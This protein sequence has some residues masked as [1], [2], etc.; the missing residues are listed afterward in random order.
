MGAWR[1]LFGR[2]MGWPR[3]I[4]L[5]RSSTR[6]NFIGAGP[7]QPGQMID[8]LK[9]NIRIRKWKPF[10]TFDDFRSK[11]IVQF[12]PISA[13][14]SS[15]PWTKPLGSYPFRMEAMSSRSITCRTRSV[16]TGCNTKRSLPVDFQVFDHR[17]RIEGR[18]FF[19]CECAGFV[20]KE[21]DS[22]R[23]EISVSEPVAGSFQMRD[24]RNGRCMGPS[25]WRG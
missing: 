22:H 16:P 6:L 7:P 11:R 8:I 20:D 5:E 15:T 14:A 1:P 10:F 19:G 4:L 24:G 3:E 17:A 23:R 21:S 12:G 13:L 2:P 25:L 9:K 18:M